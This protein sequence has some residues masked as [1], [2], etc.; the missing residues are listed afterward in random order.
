MC[1]ENRDAE[2]LAMVT[3]LVPASVGQCVH[4][5]QDSEA[6]SSDEESE[7]VCHFVYCQF[8]NLLISICEYVVLVSHI[9]CTT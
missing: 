2:V 5:R 9:G 3:Q 6:S 7:H 1:E 4:Q 8:K